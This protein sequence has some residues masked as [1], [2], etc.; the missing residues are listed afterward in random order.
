MFH[1]AEM[2]FFPT[3]SLS[4]SHLLSLSLSS[5]MAHNFK[6]FSF[7]FPHNNSQLQEVVG[8]DF[9]P[10]LLFE[11]VILNKM[12]ILVKRGLLRKSLFV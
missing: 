3:A 6:I 8:G 7:C 10:T 2:S 1:E 9:F 11:S 12:Y 5:I 4:L